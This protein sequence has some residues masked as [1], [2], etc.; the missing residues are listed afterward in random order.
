M[1]KLPKIGVRS[2]NLLEHDNIDCWTNTLIDRKILL[3][4][5]L[6][7]SATGVVSPVITETLFPESR[8]FVHQIGQVQPDHSKPGG[9]SIDF[10]SN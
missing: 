6:Q 8:L 9:A 5:A 3:E 7:A 10:R 1:P 4:I 2:F